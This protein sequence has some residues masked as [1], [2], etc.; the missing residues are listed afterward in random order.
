MRILVALCF[1]VLAV[2]VQ[3]QP[4]LHPPDQSKGQEDC[5]ATVTQSKVTSARQQVAISSKMMGVRMRVWYLSSAAE[6]RISLDEWRIRI[7]PNGK[8]HA[9]G[10]D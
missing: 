3:A 1:V 8:V 7:K 2:R 9:C 10:G 5:R 4:V 6:A